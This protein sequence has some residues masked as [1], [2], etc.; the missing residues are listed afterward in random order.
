MSPAATN[1]TVLK[2]TKKDWSTLE[3]V[4]R[5]EQVLLK[6]RGVKLQKEEKK[7]VKAHAKL[8]GRIIRD[9]KAAKIIEHCFGDEAV[10]KSMR[11]FHTEV[12]KKLGA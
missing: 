4:W 2:I 6:T 3:E 9:P 5:L 8:Y 10:L 11:A 7:E 12:M 1:D